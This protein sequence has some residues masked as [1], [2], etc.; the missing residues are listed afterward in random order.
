MMSIYS[1]PVNKKKRKRQLINHAAICT[2]LQK[3]LYI[4]V[5]AQM[6]CSYVEILLNE[7]QNTSIKFILYYY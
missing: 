4:E 2:S 3:V 5:S 1:S 7:L 6:H